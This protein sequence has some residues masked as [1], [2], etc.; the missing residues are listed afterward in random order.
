[1]TKRQRVVPDPDD[2]ELVKAWNAIAAK[3]GRPPLRR[4]DHSSCPP[5][6]PARGES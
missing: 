3:D 2:Y 5:E 4:F 6:C 1:M